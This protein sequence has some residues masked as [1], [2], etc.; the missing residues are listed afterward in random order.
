[1]R[2]SRF[3]DRIIVN[4]VLLLKKAFYFGQCLRSFQYIFNFYSFQSSPLPLALTIMSLKREAGGNMK[5]KGFLR[6][7]CDKC[8]IFN[9]LISFE[10]HSISMEA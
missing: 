6:F 2:G 10:L 7:D 3:V 5:I 1:M 8:S 9:V 4:R